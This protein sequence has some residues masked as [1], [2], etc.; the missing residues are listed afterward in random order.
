MKA[1]DNV[2]TKHSLPLLITKSASSRKLVGMI[3]F[4]AVFTTSGITGV[5]LPDIIPAPP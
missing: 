5:A 3:G 4:D 2:I 1:F